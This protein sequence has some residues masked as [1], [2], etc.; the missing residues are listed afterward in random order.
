DKGESFR[1]SGKGKLEASIS[2][3]ASQCFNRRDYEGRKQ[4]IPHT[5]AGEHLGFADF[6]D[7]WHF[8]WGKSI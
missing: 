2:A 4:D 6:L 8:S 5:Q 1:L 7:W 3:R